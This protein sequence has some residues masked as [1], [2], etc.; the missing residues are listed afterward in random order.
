MYVF[1]VTTA[2]RQYV[3]GT[4]DGVALHCVRRVFDS[5]VHFVKG[6]RTYLR[7]VGIHQPL[8]M[9]LQ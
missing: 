9:Q 6:R 8:L 3:L 2:H 7:V 1:E 4:C 5:G